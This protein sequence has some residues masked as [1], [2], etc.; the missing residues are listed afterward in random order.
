M[1]TLFFNHFRVKKTNDRV[2]DVLLRHYPNGQV[3]APD[4]LRGKKPT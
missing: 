1:Q 3:E 4:D 2:L